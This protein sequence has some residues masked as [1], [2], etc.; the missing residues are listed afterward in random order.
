MHDL[1][2]TPSFFVCSI[3][4]DPY[5]FSHSSSPS[6]PSPNSNTEYSHP[7]SL[8]H[9]SQSSTRSPRFV[10]LSVHLDASSSLPV[11]KLTLEASLLVQVWTI[12]PGTYIKLA[13]GAVS[14]QRIAAYLAGSE[15]DPPLP[16]TSTSP[17][18]DSEASTSTS[19]GYHSATIL[20]PTQIPVSSAVVSSSSSSSNTTTFSLQDLTVDIPRGELT[21]VC[22]KVGAGKSLFLLGLLGEGD[23]AEGGEVVFPRS[24]DAGGGR[25]VVAEGEDWLIEGSS[26]VPQV[27]RFLLGTLLHQTSIFLKPS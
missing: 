9:P 10:A 25:V 6:S 3:T 27:S 20:Y 8:S 24:V 17:P 2:S 19:F 14:L 18:S 16:P 1:T 13:E 21:L 12:L 15:I 11:F 5:R 4:G 26:F 7:P 23:L 22:G